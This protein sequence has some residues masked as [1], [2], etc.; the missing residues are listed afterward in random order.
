MVAIAGTALA[1]SSLLAFDVA[2]AQ[3][4]FSKLQTAT[5]AATLAATRDIDSPT[6]ETDIRQVFDANFPPGYLGSKAAKIETVLR[7][8]SGLVQ[9][10]H[11]A[12]TVELP[13]PIAG[14]VRKAGSDMHLLSVETRT[15]RRTHGAE[16]AL[17]LDNTGSMLKNNKI[18]S[19]RSASKVL[20]D[21]LFSGK[22]SVPNL[23]VAVVPYTGR[24]NIGTQ[25]KHWTRDPGLNLLNKHTWSDYA[26]E[27]WGGCVLA[28]PS[29]LDVSDLPPSVR[30]F[31][32]LFWPSSVIGGK[33]NQSNPAFQTVFYTKGN[34][35]NVWP[36]AAGNTSDGPTPN[37]VYGPNADCATPIT[38]LTSSY[39]ALWTAVDR[40]KA[41]YYGGTLANVG[42]VWGWRT[43]SPLWR[44]L[45]FQND[46]SPA[47]DNRPMD[48]LSP[49]NSK[50]IVLM[51]DG[52]N[53]L[54]GDRMMA[55]GRPDWTGLKASMLD[56][57]MLNACAA[58]KAAGIILFTIT[59]GD[60]VNI[61]TQKLYTQCASGE[62][63]SPLFP[64]Q[65]Y[66]HAPSASEL[67]AAFGNIGGQLSELRIVQ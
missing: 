36:D 19:L 61:A 51:T 67:T 15:E 37:K 66:F 41:K 43:L 10:M 56:T 42:L 53:A 34:D 64:G 59:F 8:S 2:R 63:D 60:D 50:V 6:L 28:R 62:S 40:Q 5:D 14:M 29:P 9:Q 22:E 20:L 12:V 21:I 46:G 23:Y 47:P 32:P 11:L 65:K 54:V 55:Y 39:R 31:D 33:V 49:D 45:W 26:P 44:G 30:G 1:L 16:L 4:V 57:Y 52:D 48:Y 3:M 24:V 58:I 35:K 25:H 7:Y 17:V 27:K 38:P 13:S 18:G